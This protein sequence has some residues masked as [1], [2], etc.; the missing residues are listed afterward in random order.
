MDNYD[1]SFDGG[2]IKGPPGGKINGDVGLSDDTF[3]SPAQSRSLNEL[4]VPLVK[5]VNKSL[6]NSFGF[7]L[8]SSVHDR[9]SFLL[10][11]KLS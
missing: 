2:T 5:Q 11:S 6:L 7:H 10:N 3:K 4:I 9:C 8:L 1:W